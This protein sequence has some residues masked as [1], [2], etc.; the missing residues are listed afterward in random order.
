[1]LHDNLPQVLRLKT[2]AIYY[3]TVLKSKSPDGLGHILSFSVHKVEIKISA[4]LGSYI[5]VLG[6]NL[7]S[8]SFMLL[9]EFSSCAYY[10]CR[11]EVPI[12][13]VARDFSAL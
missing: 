8:N 10:G 4:W 12:S 6:K 2:I 3:L 1:M 11:T 13:F 9:A 5:E 7:L